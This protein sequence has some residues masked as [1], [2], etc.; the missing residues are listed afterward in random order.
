LDLLDKATLSVSELGGITE[1]DINHHTILG[2]IESIIASIDPEKE[3]KSEAKSS[4]NSE[5]TQFLVK[6]EKLKLTTFDDNYGN[7]LEFKEMFVTLVKDATD[8]PPIVKLQHL[9]NSLEPD[10]RGIV[11]GVEFLAIGFTTAWDILCKRFDNTRLI[12]EIT[13][14]KF[15]TSSHL[16]GNLRQT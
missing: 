7:W 13:F 5:T 8:L 12:I 15:S 3:S 6:L 2:W 10:I 1:F 14:N 9:L 16:K 11:S 4:V